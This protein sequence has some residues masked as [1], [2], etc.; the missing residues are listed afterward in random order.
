MFAACTIVSR[1]Y[2]HFARTLGDS[3]LA[4]HPD[5]RFFVLLVDRRDTQWVPPIE[6]FDVVWLEDLCLPDLVELAFKFSILELNTAVKPTF[7]RWL[8]ERCGISKVVYLDPDIFVYARLEE[9]E[10]ALE[11]SAD[12]VLTPHTLRPID[13]DG[14]PSEQDF[15]LSGVYNLGFIGVAHRPGA[16]EFLKWWERRCLALGYSDQSVGLFVDQRWID[17]APCL[18]DKVMILRH[19]GYNV[20][21]WNLHER[22]VSL[23]NGSWSVN[24]HL[25]LRFFHFSG[26]SLDDGSQLSKYQNRFDLTARVDVAPLFDAYRCAV[27]SNG[28]LESRMTPYG[29]ATFSNG[30]W[31]N[32]LTRRVYAIVREHFGDADPFDA[33][34]RFYRYAVRRGLVERRATAEGAGRVRVTESDVR[35]RLIDGVLGLLLRLLGPSRYMML[36]RYLSHISV[37]RNQRTLFRPAS[38]SRR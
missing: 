18:F 12:V 5:S 19:A 9:V 6:R 17:L 2:L 26:I 28:A 14:R 27:F 24:Q 15:L 30:V 10:Q 7:L 16:I 31:I 23:V 3:F 1:N 36:M 34:G 33:E 13:D 25:T 35:V 32:D 8:L 21:Y 29:F 22:S 4:A 38:G 11:G 20:A 37:V